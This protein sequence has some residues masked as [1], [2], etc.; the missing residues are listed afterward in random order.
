MFPK[1]ISNI[2]KLWQ[3]GKSEEALKLH[4]KAA[5]AEQP[6]KSGIAATKYAAAIFAAKEAGVEDAVNKLKPRRPYIEPTD[7]VKKVVQE[8][9]AEMASIEAGFP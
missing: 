1:S 9:M 3:E 6:C 2:Y 5:L 7:D 8:M 4:Q